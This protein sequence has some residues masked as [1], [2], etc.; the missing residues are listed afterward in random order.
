MLLRER[1]REAGWSGARSA[2]AQRFRRRGRHPP[3]AR[4]P[5]ALPH[6]PLPAADRRVRARLAGLAPP[7]QRYGHDLIVWAGLARYHRHLQR[8][9]IRADLTRQGIALSAGSVSALC[10]RFLAALACPMAMPCISTPPATRVRAAP[11]CAWT[12]GPAGCC[13][14]RGSDQRSSGPSPAVERTLAACGGPAAGASNA[15]Y[16]RSP[17]PWPSWDVWILRHGPRDPAGARLGRVRRVAGHPWPI[18]RGTAL[19]AAPGS[20]RPARAGRWPSSTAPTTSSSTSSPSQNRACGGDWAVPI[21]A[22]IW[23]TSRRRPP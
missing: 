15:C 10:E 17:R 21:R 19:R 2:A 12:P 20:L 3:G 23:K 18:R 8:E 5:Q 4:N 13:T 14:R 22:A 6:L 11:S 1:A 7:G 9:E 16:G